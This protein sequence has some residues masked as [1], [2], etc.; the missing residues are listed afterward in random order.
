MERRHHK[1]ITI[2][3]NAESITGDTN[4][5]VFIENVSESGIS[6]IT[7]PSSIPKDFTQDQTI[8]LQLKLSSKEILGLRCKVKWSH[9]TAPRSSEYSVG[10]EIIEPPEAYINFVRTLQ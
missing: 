4:F 3:L 9:R 10:L 8:K 7:A 6:M 1:R 2:R 5:S